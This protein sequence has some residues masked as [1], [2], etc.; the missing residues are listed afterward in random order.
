MK[1]GAAAALS[2]PILIYAAMY[3][4]WPVAHLFLPDDAFYYFEIARRVAAGQGSTFDGIHPTNGYHPLWCGVLSVLGLLPL[5]KNAFV[6]AALLLQCG[7]LAAAVMELYRICVREEGR[8][9]LTAVAVSVVWLGNFYVSKTVVNGMES[10]LLAAASVG[11]LGVSADRIA[12]EERL[13]VKDGAV[14]G[15][16][17]AVVLMSRLDSFF[18]LGAIAAVWGVSRRDKLK[19]EWAAAAAFVGVPAV[20]LAVYMGANQAVFGLP[21]PVSGYL[22]RFSGAAPRSV[23]TMAAFVPFAAVVAGVYR[24]AV[25]RW[26]ALGSKKEIAYSVLTLFVLL[27]QADSM[28]LRGEVVPAI[29]YLSQHAL[30]VLAT[31]W[32]A[33]ERLA[34]RRWAVGAVVGL[35][36]LGAAATWVI[37]LQRSSYDIYVQRREMA[38]WMNSH[39]PAGSIVGSWDAGM[40]GYYSDHPV[41]NLDGLVNSFEYAQTMR[42]GKGIEYLD[43]VGVTHLAQVFLVDF[44]HFRP[45]GYDAAELHRRAAEVVWAIESETKPVGAIIRPYLRTGKKFPMQVRV[46]SRPGAK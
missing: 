35:S 12:R 43:R 45:A 23:T 29:W 6:A 33:A 15:A 19:S 8:P 16:L 22:K 10:A 42:Q 24:G 2:A 27:M 36:A 44:D 46:Y 9:G 41:V 11:L 20:V 25:G 40:I 4:A 38:G 13:T 1:V 37:R 5:S 30:W 21:M 17:G 39:L 31:L 32:L 3:T 26:V 18:L 34:A 28:L 14:L 7:L